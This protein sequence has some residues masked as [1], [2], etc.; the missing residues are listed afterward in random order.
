MC[1]RQGGGNTLGISQQEGKQG[2]GSVVSNTV[3]LE[4]AVTTLA[5]LPRNSRTEDEGLLP[6]NDD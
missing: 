5:A 1:H 6:T 2:Q 3:V 4:T